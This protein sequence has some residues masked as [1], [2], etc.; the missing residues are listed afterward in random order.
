MPRVKQHHRSLSDTARGCGAAALSSALYGLSY[1]FTKSATSAVDPLVLLAWRFLVALVAMSA[2]WKLGLFRMNFRGKDLRALVPMCVCQPLLYYLFETFGV[3]LTAASESAAIVACIPIATLIA[4]ACL[5][6]RRPSLLQ[7]VGVVVTVVGVIVCVVSQGLTASFSL[8]GYLL[9]FGAVVA[10][11]LFSV[12]SEGLTE[13]SV[14]EKTYAQVVSG[15]LSFVVLGIGRGVAGGALAA[16]VMLPICSA[17]FFVAII[18]LGVACSVGAFL[19]S[20]CAIEL[21]GSNRSISF[22]GVG[23]VVSILSGVLI[24]GEAFSTMQVLG[25]A[26]ILVGVYVANWELIRSGC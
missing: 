19:L 7:A 13:F 5:L 4:S 11:A 23:T 18:Y 9:L 24:L 16:D 26:L 14:A 22:V 2:A 10:Y 15:A 21:V 17:G 3:S 12:F 20:N 25:T 8:P 6:G 1:L